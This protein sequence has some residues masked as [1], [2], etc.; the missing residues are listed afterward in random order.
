MDACDRIETV[1]ASLWNEEHP[2]YPVP[3]W[4]RELVAAVAVYARLPA[5]HIRVMRVRCPTTFGGRWFD[6]VCGKRRCYKHAIG[7]ILHPNRATTKAT[8]VHE[9]G[10]YVSRMRNGDKKGYHDDRFFEIVEDLYA[11]FGVSMASAKTIEN[12]HHPEDWGNVRGW[13]DLERSKRR[14]R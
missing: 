7:I 9:M 11:K 1:P 6:N 12:G 2:E 3:P 14:R 13:A 10:H 8:V 5:P 4:V